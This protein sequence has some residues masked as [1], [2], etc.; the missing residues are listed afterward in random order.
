[1]M[2]LA[3]GPVLEFRNRQQLPPHLATWK[4]GYYKSTEQHNRQQ[5]RISAIKRFESG[6]KRSSAISVMAELDSLLSSTP[7]VNLLE[8]RAHDVSLPV[9]SCITAKTVKEQDPVQ[10]DSTETRNPLFLIGLT[11]RLGLLNHSRRNGSFT[12]LISRRDSF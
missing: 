12:T 3:G 9:P 5:I 8:S 6:H 11:H 7:R 4:L 10:P 2:E 1:M